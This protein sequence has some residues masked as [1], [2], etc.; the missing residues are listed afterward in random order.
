MRE[1]RRTLLLSLALER[2]QLR[3][4]VVQL[5]IVSWP[6]VHKQRCSRVKMGRVER[7]LSS[8]RRSCQSMLVN[9]AESGA[10]R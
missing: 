8:C 9:R 5:A 1:I 7:L 6:R 2:Q 3:I 10:G 4:V